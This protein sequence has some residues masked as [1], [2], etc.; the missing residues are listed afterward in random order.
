MGELRSC[1]TTYM[2][3]VLL[4]KVS[5]IDGHRQVVSYRATEIKGEL[6]YYEVAICVERD[7]LYLLR[8]LRVRLLQGCCRLVHAQKL[9]LPVPEARSRC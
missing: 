6:T 1:R 8:R 3:S 7:E 2:N 5:T 4:A 9:Q